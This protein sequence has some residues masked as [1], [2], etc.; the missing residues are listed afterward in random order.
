[1]FYAN[2]E[3][4][5]RVRERVYIELGTLRDRYVC[6]RMF[7]EAAY[8]SVPLRKEEAKSRHAEIFLSV[9][10]DIEKESTHRPEMEPAELDR[11]EAEA[12]PWADDVAHAIA[13]RGYKI[14]ACTTMFDQTAAS[15][16]VLNRVKELCPDVVTIIGGANCEGEM[17]EGIVSLRANIDAV[18]SGESERSFT[19][20]MRQVMQGR[21]L[22]GP[23]IE[24]GM[25]EDM[26]SIPP[27]DFAEFFRQRDRLLPAS[28]IPKDSLSVPYETARGCWWGE[29]HKCKFCGL[30][31]GRARYRSKSPRKVVRELK[32]ILNSAPTR[33]VRMVDNVLPRESLLD[34]TGRLGAEIPSL[35]LFYEI[36]ATMSLREVMAIKQA[37]VSFVQA[38]LESLSTS[39]LRRMGKGTSART[40]VTLL[41]YARITGL[42]VS[43]NLLWGFPNDEAADYED[44][45]DLVPRIRH[46]QPASSLRPLSLDRFSDYFEHPEKHGIT[47]IRPRGG[48]AA[49][50]PEHADAD[51]LDCHFV[52]DFEC[53]AFANLDVI[54]RLHDELLTWQSR[55]RNAAIDLFGGL[56][57][58]EI[59]REA[60]DRY[61]LTDTRGLPG[62]GNGSTLTRRQ[63]EYA[64]VARPAEDTPDADW[65]LA[66]NVAVIRNRWLVPLATADADLLLEIEGQ[67]SRSRRRSGE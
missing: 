56:P 4:A 18:F 14:V 47:N 51:K 7:A 6:Q 23:I 43:W 22:P 9:A 40:N 13:E 57:Q 66:R 59:A 28:T 33:R 1:V 24:G 50:L 63:A 20:F 48:Y 12:V 27:P 39:L 8:G 55:W 16:A 42:R 54:H 5:A 17:A 44:I 60:D 36:R 15:V 52:G 38:G 35:D 21:P 2:M 3:F 34:L 25:C 37:G 49:F 29:K 46:L 10:S 62:T 58:L 31:G 65:A 32:G 30:N 61:R 41:R 67:F 45:L 19:D 64:L 26:E 11:I 53:G